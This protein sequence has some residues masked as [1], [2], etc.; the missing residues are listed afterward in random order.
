M[1]KKDEEKS[2]NMGGQQEYF[3]SLNK[4]KDPYF[5]MRII[6]EKVL[7]VPFRTSILGPNI[8]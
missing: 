6:H 5:A 3:F 7:T 8:L 4:E 2:R 1:P